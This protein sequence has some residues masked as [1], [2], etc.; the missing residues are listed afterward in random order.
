MEPAATLSANVI[1][2]ILSLLVPADQKETYIVTQREGRVPGQNYIVLVRTEKGFDVFEENR[3][4]GK[5]EPAGEIIFQDKPGMVEVDNG[6]KKE[7]VDLSEF[8]NALKPLDKQPKQNLTVQGK[9]V[10]IAAVGKKITLAV[11]GKTNIMVMT[12][13]KPAA[14]SRSATSR[15]APK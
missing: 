3:A 2:A 7:T 15:A 1:M 8:S 6:R 14:A 12:A 10:E 9:K 11:E 13:D 5:R 4:A